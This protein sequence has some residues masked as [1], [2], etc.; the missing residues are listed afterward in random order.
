MK[1]R[2][3]GVH[4]EGEEIEIT[5]AMI[6][7]GAAVLRDRFEPLPDLGGEAIVFVSE[8]DGLA[9][10]VLVAAFAARRT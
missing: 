3:A 7:A 10:A 2:Q 8:A 9:R 1:G 4:Q 6:E 5:P